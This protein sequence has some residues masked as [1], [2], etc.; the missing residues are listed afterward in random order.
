MPVLEERLRAESGVDFTHARYIQPHLPRLVK[1]G[2]TD[3]LG[4]LLELALILDGFE[5]PTVDAICQRCAISEQEFHDI[6]NG[7]MAE[8]VIFFAPQLG[9]QFVVDVEKT[10]EIEAEFQEFYDLY[11]RKL[12]RSKVFIAFRMARTRATFEEIM[13]GLELCLEHYCSIEEQYIP[14]PVSWLN[15]GYWRHPERRYPEIRG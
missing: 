10:S 3:A 13:Y 5:E 15:K 2:R 9:F 1:W 6:A 12:T 14:Y 11:P 4:V 8:K 7:L